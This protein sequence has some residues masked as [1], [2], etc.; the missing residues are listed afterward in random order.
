MS[1]LSY[2]IF[3]LWN[4]SKRVIS[5]DALNIKFNGSSGTSASEWV[6]G[7]ASTCVNE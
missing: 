3:S 5:N 2:A 4:L 6:S 7:L 1:D